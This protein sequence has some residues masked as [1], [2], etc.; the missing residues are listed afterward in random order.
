VATKAWPL[1]RDARTWK[2]RSNTNLREMSV[3]ECELC[4]RQLLFVEQAAL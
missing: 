2:D 4:E 1:R 3:K